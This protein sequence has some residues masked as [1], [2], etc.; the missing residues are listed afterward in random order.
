MEESEAR[1]RFASARVARLATIDDR[2]RP[3]LV[4]FVFVLDGDT[5][6]SAIDQKPKTTRR[7]QR[8][9]NIERN[10]NAAVL[11][12]HYEDDW[13]AAWWVRARGGARVIVRGDEEFSRAR[14][15]LAAKYEQYRDDPPIGPVIA[16]DIEDWRGWAHVEDRP[17]HSA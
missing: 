15:L 16:I 5:I 8:L 12:D 13:T 1:R 7:L 17:I 11:A 3:H 14:R 10:P 2:G 4:P 9:R 6:Y